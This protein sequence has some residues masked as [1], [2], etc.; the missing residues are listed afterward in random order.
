MVGPHTRRDYGS[1]M[2]ERLQELEK[3]SGLR[4]EVPQKILLAETGTLEQVL[5]ILSG[6][7]IVVKILEQTELGG[8]ISRESEIRTSSGRV[9]VRARSKIFARAVPRK[10][11]LLIRLQRKGIGSILQNN[12]LETFRKIIEIGYDPVSSNLFRKYRIIIA[13]RVGFEIREEFV[14]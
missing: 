10:I 7:G 8:I 14:R 5:S 13:K 9:L 1:S 4:V 2:L 6:E 11:L 12:E 3:R